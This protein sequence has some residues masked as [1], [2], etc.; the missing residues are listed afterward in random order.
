M[1]ED[2][3]LMGAAVMFMHV[4]LSDGKIRQPVDFDRELLGLDIVPAFVVLMA[5]GQPAWN[6]TIFCDALGELVEEGKV[7]AWKDDEG[8]HYQYEAQN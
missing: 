6:K 1:T 7:K 5:G 2:K 3:R 8:W 4:Y